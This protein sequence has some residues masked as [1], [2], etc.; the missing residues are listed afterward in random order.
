MAAV[1]RG[2][3]SRRGADVF[4]DRVR[5]TTAKRLGQALAGGAMGI[6]TRLR[7]L[8]SEWD[9]ERAVHVLISSSSLVGLSLRNALGRKWWLL[10]GALALCALQQGLSSWS[11]LLPVLR[12]LGFR[13]QREIDAERYALKAAR[14][15]FRALDVASTPGPHTLLAL[16][17]F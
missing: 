11:P 4:E 12:G 9:V 3:V 8:D 13:T 16:A 5:R 6:D 7:E 15:D 2:P 14:G 17:E 10:S 1:A